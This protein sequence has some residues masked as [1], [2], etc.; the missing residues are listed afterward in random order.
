MSAPVQRFHVRYNSG[1]TESII[2]EA[3]ERI[4]NPEDTAELE[5]EIR[6]VHQKLGRFADVEA[7][8]AFE[9]SWRFFPTIVSVVTASRFENGQ[10]TESFAFIQEGG[11]YRLVKYVAQISGED[12]V[13]GVSKGSRD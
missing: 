1:S 12:E 4:R 11:R 10:A 6:R 13:G 9:T 3:S 7:I 5:E 8:Y 2:R